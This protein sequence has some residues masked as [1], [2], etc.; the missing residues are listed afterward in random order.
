MAQEQ[1]A[2]VAVSKEWI[3]TAVRVLVNES[4]LSRS[5]ANTNILIAPLEDTSDPHGL[6]LAGVTTRGLTTDG[7]EVKMRVMVP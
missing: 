4:R 3:N 5:E 7:S 1:T 2:V 6:W